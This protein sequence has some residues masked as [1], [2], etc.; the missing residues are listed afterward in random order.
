MAR[1]IVIVDGEIVG[2]DEKLTVGL[3]EVLK[4]GEKVFPEGLKV[5]RLKNKEDFVT[6]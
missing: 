1:G 6:V 5:L 3:R 2:E 4:V